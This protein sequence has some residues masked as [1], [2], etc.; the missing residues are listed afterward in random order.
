MKVNRILE[1]LFGIVSAIFGLLC[2]LILTTS[3]ATTIV[4]RKREQNDLYNFIQENI[5]VLLCCAAVVIL[6]TF[7]LYKKDKF[8]RFLNIGKKRNTAIGLFE[9]LMYCVAVSLGLFLIFSIQGLATNDA[10]LLDDVISQ[11]MEGDY[12]SIQNGYLALYPFQIGY[13]MIGQIIYILAGPSNYLVYQILNVICIL[14]TMY[15]LYRI[16][17]LVFH[18]RK[19]AEIMAFF[20]IGAWFYYAYATFVYNDVWSNALQFA[21]F[22][23]LLV[24]LQRGMLLNGIEAAIFIA[25]ACLVKSNCYIALIAMAVTILLSVVRSWISVDKRLEKVKR[26][27]EN[28]AKLGI[29]ALMLALTLSISYSVRT[30]YAHKAGMNKMRNGV[31]ALNYFAMGMQETEGKYGWY[32]GFNASVYADNNYDT[33]LANAESIEKIHE[34]IAAFQNSKR[35]LVKFYLVKFLSQWADPTDV[36]LRE[37]EETARHVENQPQIA[38]SIVF[39][40]I[41]HLMQWVMNVYQTV[42]YLFV[43]CY[44]AIRLFQVWKKRKAVGWNIS[45]AGGLEAIF[46]SDGEILMIIFIIGGMIFHKFWEASGR[47][48]MRYY[49]TMLPLAAEGADMVMKKMSHHRIHAGFRQGKANE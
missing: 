29:I 4:F 31:S 38:Q 49:L 2:L 46:F 8:G 43:V 35:Y 48:T 1:I 11:F 47:Y 37:Q 15:F 34:S 17:E 5:P 41:Y 40:K 32:N 20:A 30:Y 23:F 16:T 26:R 13:V 7:Y 36:S 28:F 24:Y 39:G 22:Y 12:S 25:L 3:I 14:S 6:V 21:A 42:I 44:I 27:R 19:T 18:N 45:S 9:F 10:G 33:D